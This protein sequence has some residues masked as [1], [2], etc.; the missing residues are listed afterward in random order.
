MAKVEPPHDYRFKILLVGESGV[1]KTCLLQRF[2]EETF[3]KSYTATIGVDY[4][5]KTVQLGSDIVRLQIWDTAGQERFKTLTAAYYRGANGILLVYDITQER[6][7]DQLTTWLKSIE[8]EAPDTIEMG[9]VGNKCDLDDRREVSVQQ[10]KM[11]AD[12]HGLFCMEVSALENSNVEEAFMSLAQKI[13]E[14]HL[15]ALP[16]SHLV[17]SNS[18]EI[19]DSDLQPGNCT[20]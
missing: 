15:G 9:V 10:G 16:T 18:F 13:L 11:F 20:C 7:F 6:S 17:R 14:R 5:V 3:K 19:S 2:T 8:E 12:A 1:G 4:K